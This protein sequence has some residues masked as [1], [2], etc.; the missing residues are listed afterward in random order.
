MIPVASMQG[1][2]NVA[3]HRPG[4]SF[5]HDDLFTQLQETKGK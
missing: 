1:K 2:P 4:D 5:K 3:C